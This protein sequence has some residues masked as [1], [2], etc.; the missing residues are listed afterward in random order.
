MSQD[1]GGQKDQKADPVSQENQ[2]CPETQVKVDQMGNKV[3]VDSVDREAAQEAGVFQA[4]QGQPEPQANQDSLVLKDN[5]ED[6]AHKGHQGHKDQLDQMDSLVL[7]VQLAPL[8]QPVQ[9]EEL[10]PRDL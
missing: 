10:A 8:G 6:Q 7:G 4:Q 1:Q 9:Q 2:G 3:D 5:V